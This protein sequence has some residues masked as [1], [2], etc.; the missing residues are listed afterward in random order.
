MKSQH[1][2]VV[3]DSPIIRR[4]LVGMLTTAGYSVL[5]A[6]DGA[7]A[8]KLAK[9][10]LPRLILLDVQMPGI[11]GYTVCRQLKQQEATQAIPVIFVSSADD[12][13]AETASFEA[14][15]ADYVTKPPRASTLLARVR[16]HIALHAQRRSLEGMFRDV[17]ELAPVAFIFSDVEGKVA[18][19]NAIAAQ[20]LGYPRNE[21]AGLP[22]ETLIP[23]CG[24]YIPPDSPVVDANE[25]LRPATSVEILCRRQ[26]G[27][28][29]PV[30][31]LFTRLQTPRG[32]LIMA[33]LQNITER[34]KMLFELGESRSLIRDLAAQREAAREQERKHIAREVHD[35]LGQVLTALRMDMSLIRMQYKAQEPA[36]VEKLED[37][38]I[39]VDRAI[40]DVRNI[41]GDLRP[42]AL[43][44]G[45]FA[46]ID[47]LK[48]EFVRRTEVPCALDFQCSSLQLDELRA[49]VLYRIV[50]ES[51]TNVAKYAKASEVHITVKHTNQRVLLSV[52]DDGCGFD[53]VRAL[54]RNTFGLLGMR[55]R[56]LV[57]FGSFHVDSH[58]GQGTRI[59]ISFPL[60]VP[61]NE[62]SL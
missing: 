2:L 36:L 62:D 40:A 33:V 61:L 3:D 58:P 38:R 17:V 51:L 6:G 21:L 22:I 47:W 53:M 43:D 18:M 54:R 8:L 16:T 28:E 41:A 23:L 24:P 48:D 1:I 5:E 25:S 4:L 10:S 11:N 26:D 59:E 35:E 42:S 49:V 52:I 30:D 7:L 14:G 39:L 27:T 50:Q 12:V 55:E 20:Q 13:E 15:G 29:F 44:M 60:N 32:G 31:A 46:A 57:L 9:E 34:K 37:M 45:L 56:A 19:V